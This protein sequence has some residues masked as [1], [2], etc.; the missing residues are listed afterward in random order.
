MQ[1][2]KRMLFAGFIMI[3]LTLS[4]SITKFQIVDAQQAYMSV[5]ALDTGGKFFGPQIIQIIIDGSGIG[6]PNTSAG[7]LIVNGVNVPLV[8]LSD[9]RWYA[10]VAD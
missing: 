10:Y 6:E 4:L 5:S 1:V 3:V 7:A 8:H 9:S 2:L